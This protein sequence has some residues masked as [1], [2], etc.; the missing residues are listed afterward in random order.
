MRFVTVGANKRVYEV[1]D[2]WAEAEEMISKGMAYYDGRGGNVAQQSI[3]MRVA[4]G[5]F[6]EQMMAADPTQAL[7]YLMHKICQR[8][9]AG[10]ES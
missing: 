1:P 3:A 4:Y 8:K 10:L 2:T 6:G 9:G 5:M 7:M